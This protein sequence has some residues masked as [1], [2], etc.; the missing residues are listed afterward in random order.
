MEPIFQNLYEFLSKGKKVVLATLIRQWGSSPRATGTKCLI[1]PQGTITGTIGGGRLEAEV[2]EMAK[3]V[4]KTG[5]NRLIPFNL[6]GKDVAETDMIC[7]G[8]V[9][10]YLELVSPHNQTNLAICKEI[11]NI[12]RKGGKA[13]LATLIRP[14]LPGS[15]RTDLQALFQKDGSVLG[16]L[17]DK[18]FTDVIQ[19]AW[20]KG[21][22]KDMPE[23]LEFEKGDRLYAF[24]LETISGQESVYLLGAGHIAR[25]LAPVLKLVHFRVVVVDDRAEFASKDHFPDADD[26]LV[27]PFEGAL[28]ALEMGDG[29]Y[30]V[31][32]TRGHLYDHILLAQALKKEVEYIELHRFA[33]RLYKMKKRIQKKKRVDSQKANLYTDALKEEI[34]KYSEVPGNFVDKLFSNPGNDFDYYQTAANFL[35]ALRVKDVFFNSNNKNNRKKIIFEIYKMNIPA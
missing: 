6:T 23:T 22:I 15:E 1:H 26:V 24:Y 29:D 16:T 31:I 5:Q 10:A 33:R 14:D 17:L 25:K 20:M 27:M 28:D 30:L 21:E 8:K 2:M 11:R 9:D 7:G 32:I 35:T 4:F 3:E 13:L 12:L 18:D 34:S 19:K